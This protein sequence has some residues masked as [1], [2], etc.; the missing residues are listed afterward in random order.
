MTLMFSGEI[1][2]VAITYPHTSAKN[3][4]SSFTLM[5]YVF[6]HLSAKVQTLPLW[7]LPI[8]F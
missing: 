6:S 1:K 7:L 5:V 3:L 8:P 2:F 4:T